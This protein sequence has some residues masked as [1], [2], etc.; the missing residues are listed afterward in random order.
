MKKI[1]L[2]I[3][4]TMCLGFSQ[5]WGLQDACSIVG[6]KMALPEGNLSNWQPATTM[7]SP[8]PDCAGT[9]EFTW[10]DGRKTI[11]PYSGVGKTLNIGGVICN[12]NDGALTNC[13][14]YDDY[15]KNHG[16]LRLGFPGKQMLEMYR[17]IMVVP[18]WP[19]KFT[20]IPQ[21]N[22]SDRFSVYGYTLT[23]WI[24]NDECSP[25]P[26]DA[27]TVTLI[28]PD[29]SIILLPYARTEPGKALVAGYPCQLVKG[30]LKCDI[31]E[32]NY[33]TAVKE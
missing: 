29:G 26:K 5:A 33:F 14:G 19:E 28:S 30:N 13:T 6:Q 8:A 4:I 12:I 2:A 3:L 25:A 23:N 27:G 24:P 18:P 15:I 22:Y 11:E 32:H 9:V 17:A 20:E 10:K 21:I 1:F 7:F 16:W 31:I